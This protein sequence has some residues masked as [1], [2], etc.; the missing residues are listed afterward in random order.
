MKPVETVFTSGLDGK[1]HPWLDPRSRRPMAIGHYGCCVDSP[2]SARVVENSSFE[3][4]G[5]E[6]PL[7]LVECC[8]EC[9]DVTGSALENWIEVSIRPLPDSSVK[10]RW[11][12]VGSKSPGHRLIVVRGHRVALSNGGGGGGT[13]DRSPDSTFRALFTCFCGSAERAFC[14]TAS[15]YWTYRQHNHHQSLFSLFPPN[16]R[17]SPLNGRST[18]SSGY[19]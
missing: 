15:F 19:I 5:G 2:E 9:A 6:T 10:P 13:A 3:S 11:L 1:P 12:G 17:F 14:H 7:G 18:C 8:T 16:G 4:A